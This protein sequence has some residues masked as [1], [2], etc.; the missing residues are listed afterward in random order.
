V[1]GGVLG[2]GLQGGYVIEYTSEDFLDIN[3]VVLATGGEYAGYLND[4]EPFTPMPKTRGDVFVRYDHGIHNA[5]VIFR[6]V[7]SYE[8]R[9]PAVSTVRDLSEINDQLTADLHYNVRLFDNTTNL[10]LS[11]IN[12]TDK[13]PPLAGTG[14]NYDAFTHNPLGRVFKV[15]LKYFFSR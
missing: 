5:Q 2:V 13:D 1:F 4:A 3:G 12:V 9:T 14:L 11:V 15:G 6:Y 8:D 10:S 7:S